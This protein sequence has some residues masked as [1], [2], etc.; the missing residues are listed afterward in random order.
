M[1]RSFILYG[2]DRP[3]CDF[4]APTLW[5]LGSHTATAHHHDTIGEH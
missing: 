1:R 2:C 3:G 4:N 5:A